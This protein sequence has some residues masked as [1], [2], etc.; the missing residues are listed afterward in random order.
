MRQGVAERGLYICTAS[1]LTMDP[2]SL[3]VARCRTTSWCPQFCS[4][5]NLIKHTLWLTAG[6]ASL[7]CTACCLMLQDWDTGE[8]PLSFRNRNYIF[9]FK[10]RNPSIE[11]LRELARSKKVRAAVCP[12]AIA[13][14]KP[15]GLPRSTACIFVGV[16]V[17]CRAAAC[18]WKPTARAG[19]ASPVGRST[20]NHGHWGESMEHL[21]GCRLAGAQP[22]APCKPHDVTAAACIW[23]SCGLSHCVG[24]FDAACHPNEC[25]PGR[26]CALCRL[27]LAASVSCPGWDTMMCLSWSVMVTGNFTL[28]ASS[29][30]CIHQDT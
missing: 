6:P 4:E 16:M 19:W 13:A 3:D 28:S 29:A 5:P 30:C 17:L 25:R 22:G 27:V 14:T 1:A 2:E 18:Q 7:Q 8:V 21:S 26:G 9:T 23:S 12:P 20:H 11:A 10:Y 24:Q 15:R